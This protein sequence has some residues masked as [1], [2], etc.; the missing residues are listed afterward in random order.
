MHRGAVLPRR[1][2]QPADRHPHTTAD[3]LAFVKAIPP[4]VLLVLD[5][6]TLNS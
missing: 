1:T 3:L 5:E 4:N 2:E 6:L